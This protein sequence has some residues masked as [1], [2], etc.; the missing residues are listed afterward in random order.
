MNTFQRLLHR[1]FFIRLLNWE[2]WPFA[3]V[4]GPILPVYFLLAAR[5]RALFFF[6]ASNPSI[7]TG[8][9]MMES[10]KKIYDILPA[11]TYPRT[12]FFALPADVSAVVH[13]VREA[14][15]RYP[16]IAKPDIGAKGMGVR[17]LDDEA[18]L[19]RYCE[20]SPMDF[21]V[22]E[23]IHFEKEAGVFF[24]RMP[25]E[26]CG[27]ITG[28]VRKEF[29]KVTGDGIQ[30]IRQLILKEK[31]FI[32]QLQALEQMHSGF[33][34]AVLPNGVEQVLV[35]YGNHAR[36]SKFLD[37]TDLV[38]AELQ[39]VFNTLC[40]KIPGFYYGRLDIRYESWEKLRKG[41]AFSIIELNGAGSEPTH[42]Y[43]PRHSVFYA[44]NEIIRHWF[45]LFRISRANHKKGIP[46]MSFAEG[47]QMF[48][49]NTAFEQKMEQ[50]YV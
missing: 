29:V 32:L 42:I 15:F 5:A 11:G 47:R 25:D 39:D 2:Y 31:R 12:M 7:E 48:R 41:E 19:A 43:D 16:L 17:K 22:Q 45:W 8:G 13:A 9:F 37:D 20:E 18:E 14:G 6:S 28:I 24:C 10:K 3:V 34:D 1:P 38:D 21:L 46:Y 49:D 36:G 44:W 4:Y 35:P 23:Y 30:T 50:L 26:T 40:T 33:L 27:R